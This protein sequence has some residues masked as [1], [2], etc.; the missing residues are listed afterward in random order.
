MLKFA[1]FFMLILLF[2]LAL[3]TSIVME[4]KVILN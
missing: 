4:H 2:A 3:F 1:V